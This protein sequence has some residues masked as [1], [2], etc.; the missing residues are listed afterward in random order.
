MES[1]FEV[2][3]DSLAYGGDGVGRLP[4][5]RVAF[6]PY[7]IPGEM[8][9]VKVVEEKA[10]HTRAESIDILEPSSERVHPRCV[11]FGTC[12]GCHYQQ[13]SYSAQL[14]AK[15]GILREQLTRIG[16]LKDIPEIKIVPAP[17]PWYYRNHLQFHQTGEGRLGFQ[18]AHSHQTFAIKECH[19]PESGINRLWPQLEIEPLTGIQRISLRQGM[20]DDLMII[21]DGSSPDELDFEVENLSISV[22]RVDP[23]GSTVLAGS[24]HLIMEVLGRKF[25]VSA[26]SFFQVN[27]SQAGAMVNLLLEQ[28]PLDKHMTILDVYSGVGLF[29]AFLAEKVNRLVGV[30]ISPEACGDFE[31]NLDEFDHVELYEAAAEN[32]LSNVQF[33]PQVIVMDPPRTGLG[34]KTVEGIVNQGASTLAYISC[35]PAT[36]A[37]DGKQLTSAGYTIKQLTVIDMFPQTF[38]IESMSVWEK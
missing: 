20:D 35:D 1:L 16:D 24:D 15:A 6:V 9:R 2:R 25:K 22:V 13:M 14:S 36:L 28:L 21:L 5:G 3:I 33:H 18:R 19:L 29:S 12:G 34:R 27:T 4:D 23:S 38:H 10:H 7:T 26:S 31:T 17:V 37:R 8:V 32:V 11:H 30:E